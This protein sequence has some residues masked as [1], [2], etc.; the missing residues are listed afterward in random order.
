MRISE[1]K[2]DPVWIRHLPARQSYFLHHQFS[3]K[4]HSDFTAQPWGTREP[5]A[6]SRL[7]FISS[8]IHLFKSHGG[9]VCIYAAKLFCSKAVFDAKE[10]LFFVTHILKM[11]Q[12]ESVQ[13]FLTWPGWNTWILVL[14]KWYHSPETSLLAGLIFKSWPAAA[15]LILC[16]WLSWHSHQD[17]MHSL[18][19]IQASTCPFFLSQE[20]HSETC[21]LIIC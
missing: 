13:V 17:F 3:A 6:P 5:W 14:C 20:P 4:S 10:K 11:L 2:T 8:R 1:G 9:S 7:P 18:T 19:K 16:L 12:M 21:F 15:H